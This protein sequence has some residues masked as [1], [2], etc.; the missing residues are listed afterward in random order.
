[1]MRARPELAGKLLIEN[2]WDWRI[3]DALAPAPGEHVVKRT[4]YSGF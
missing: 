2:T 4:R 3:V 1:M